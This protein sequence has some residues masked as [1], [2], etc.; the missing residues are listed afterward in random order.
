MVKALIDVSKKANRIINIVKAKYG[1]KTKSQA[2]NKMVEE[3]EEFLLEPQLRPDYVK[4]LRKIERG[5]TI[6]QQEFEK[7]FKIKL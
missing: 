4:K 5:G 1:L 6:S 7:K 2:I 3:F